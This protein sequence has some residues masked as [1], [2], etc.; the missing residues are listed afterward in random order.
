MKKIHVIMEMSLGAP[1]LLEI[2]P[3]DFEEA[4]WQKKPREGLRNYSIQQ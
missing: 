3:L 2:Y 4:M 1:I